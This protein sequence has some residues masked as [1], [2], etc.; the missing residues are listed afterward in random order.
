MSIGAGNKRHVIIL[1]IVF[2]GFVIFELAFVGLLFGVVI[3]AHCYPTLTRYGN[4]LSCFL[5]MLYSFGYVDIYL[6]CYG[7]MRS[8]TRNAFV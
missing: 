6:V 5:A 3:N 2:L 1:G 4:E 8:R 7:D